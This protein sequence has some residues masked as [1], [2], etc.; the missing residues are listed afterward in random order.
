MLTTTNKCLDGREGVVRTAEEMPVKVERSELSFPEAEIVRPKAG[1]AWGGLRLLMGFTFLWAFLD[2]L[3]A[4]G[5]ATGRNP[6]T[7]SID[8]FGKAAWIHGGSP[9]DG[10]LKFGLHT[11]DPFLSFY[12]GLA[13]STW[14]EWVFMLSMAAIGLGLLFGIGTRLAAIGGI[15]WMAIFYTAT[16]IWPANNPFVDEHIIYIVVLAGIAYV[17]AGRFLGLGN[18]WRKTALVKRYPIFE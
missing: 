2:K 11:K 3:L 15:I 7:G 4:L 6:V 12:Q 18:W 1:I 17:G 8:F 13:G 9:T 16:A 14:V 5:F 10:L